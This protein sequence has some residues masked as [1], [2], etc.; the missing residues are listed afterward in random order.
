MM[1]SANGKVLIVGFEIDST[2]QIKVFQNVNNEWNERT[3][4][5]NQNLVN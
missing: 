5:A 3:L 1:L 4:D 2:G